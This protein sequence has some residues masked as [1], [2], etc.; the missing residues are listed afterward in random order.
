MVIS[1]KDQSLEARLA[2]TSKR[3]ALSPSLM[4]RRD[5]ARWYWL[6]DEHEPLQLDY[7]E[8]LVVCSIV[9]STRL[10]D[11]PSRIKK[12]PL[13]VEDCIR[14]TTRQRSKTDRL[15]IDLDT[16]CAKLRAA[17]PLQLAGLVARSE[18]YTKKEKI[19]MAIVEE[20]DDVDA[21]EQF[22]EA[23][24][25][26]SETA[27]NLLPEADDVFWAQ[28]G[29]HSPTWEQVF[30]LG[31]ML[32]K[33]NSR[34]EALKLTQKLVESIWEND[35]E[36]TSEIELS[37]DV[38]SETSGPPGAI[39]ELYPEKVSKITFNKSSKEFEITCTGSFSMDDGMSLTGTLRLFLGSDGMDF[40]DFERDSS[41][42]HDED[43]EG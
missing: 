23:L 10:F 20:N 5:L 43:A 37:Y 17:T 18:Q 32:L 39:D 21:F 34:T 9:K 19:S 40:R 24:D 28:F 11:E 22:Q 27:A 41:G 3:Q 25:N 36:R 6:L 42:D 35:S 8:F 33:K 14:S 4:A 2:E 30:D 1:F 12:M 31:V 7:K 38:A 26:D 29:E 15:G 13:L 16:L